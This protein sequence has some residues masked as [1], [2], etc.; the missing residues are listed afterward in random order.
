MLASAEGR[1]PEEEDPARPT[2]A[3]G[4]LTA[5]GTVEGRPVA[6]A[7]YDF[8]VLGGTHRGGRGAQGDAAAGPRAE[9][10]DADRVA[11]GLGR[12]AAGGGRARSI[13]GGSPASRTP[14]TCSASRAILSGVVPQVAAMLGPGA[15]G[16]AYIPGLADYVPMVKDIGSI[17]V[18]GPA[19][20]ESTVGEKVTEQQLGGSKVHNEV[21]GVA[22]G[23]FADDAACIAA[24]RTYL[25]FFPSH[26]EE[27]PPRRRRPAI[28]R[29][30]ATSRCSTWCRTTRARRSTCTRSSRRSSTTGQFFPLKPR[31]ARNVITGLCR[32]DGWSVGVVASNSM[33]L[34]GVL[35]VAASD[36][37]ARFVGL[38]RR[39]PAFPC[40]SSRTSPASWWGPRPSSSGLIRH[41]ARMLQLVSN[42]TVPK[43]TVVV[44]KGFGAGLLR[45]ERPGL[46]AGPPGR[47]AGGGDRRS[48]A[49][50]GWSPSPR[51]EAAGEGREPRGREG[52][53]GRAGRRATPSRRASTGPRRWGWWTT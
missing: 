24:V 25:S 10:P 41:G 22:D 35:D 27:R 51:E 5:F 6:A 40:S 20:V 48:W 15:A 16:T 8:T 43:L 12:R 17:A 9:G 30:G 3:D 2:A 53:E 39:L 42:A 37:A 38:V 36:K 52:D 33:F 26:C 18:G 32:I 49:R 11:G 7:I 21:S 45:D 29:T 47:L 46:R 1:L 50:R 31:F 44:R 4:V 19:L 23:E 14:G 28:P 34:G 13:H